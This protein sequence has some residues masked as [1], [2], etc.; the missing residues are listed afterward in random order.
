MFKIEDE[1]IHCTRGDK[2]NIN[3]SCPNKDGTNY[4]FQQGQIII[5]KVYDSKDVEKVVLQ[6]DV[7]VENDCSSVIIPLTSEDTTI[8]DYINKKK[9]YS[10]EIS[11]NDDM[12]VIGYD[13]EGSKLFVLYPEAGKK[14]N[15]GE[16]L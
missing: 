4:I 5:F 7:K 10:Y 6:K 2:G 12:T 13:E 3:F 16:V 8:G 11:I 1:I 15:G 9:T 14:E